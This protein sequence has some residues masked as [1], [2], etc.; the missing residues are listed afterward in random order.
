MCTQQ[1]GPQC[2]CTRVVNCRCK[3]LKFQMWFPIDSISSIQCN[4]LTYYNGLHCCVSECVPRISSIEFM[5]FMRWFMV[6][7]VSPA[8]TDLF[9]MWAISIWSTNGRPHRKII[10]VDKRIIAGVCARVHFGEILIYDFSIEFA[11]IWCMLYLYKHTHT[12]SDYLLWIY[13]IVFG[14][15]SPLFDCD[16]ILAF[17]AWITFQFYKCVFVN[18]KKM[19]L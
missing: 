4:P 14:I 15:Q 7:S 19:P 13:C 17:M 6:I 2:V 10:A 16:G 8:L 3:C 11:A 9:Y 12:H 18:L 1:S 5:N